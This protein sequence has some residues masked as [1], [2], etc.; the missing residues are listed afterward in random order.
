MDLI[1]FAA[2]H[3]PA[4]GV[5][6]TPPSTTSH[7]RLNPI[8]ALHLPHSPG[9]PIPHTFREVIGTTGCTEFHP[10]PLWFTKQNKQQQRK[11]SG[12]EIIQQAAYVCSHASGDYQVGDA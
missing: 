4:R 6:S 5:P 3:R 2:D 9:S 12:F 11:H 10:Q 7:W 1:S 8:L